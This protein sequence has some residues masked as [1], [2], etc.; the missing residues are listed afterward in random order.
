MY[1]DVT[2]RPTTTTV[3]IDS[4]Y[5]V[6]YEKSIGP[7]LNVLDIC[8]CIFVIDASYGPPYI[9]NTDKNYFVRTKY[10][11]HINEILG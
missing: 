2:V 5:E 3:T 9:R 10:L 1:C 7:K 8:R 4:L 6:V 11:F